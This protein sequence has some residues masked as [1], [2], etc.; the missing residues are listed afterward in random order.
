ME[1][2]TNVE[3]EKKMLKMKMFRIYLFIYLHVEMEA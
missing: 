1:A 3:N 2:T